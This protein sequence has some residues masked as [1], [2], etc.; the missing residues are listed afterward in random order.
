MKKILVVDDDQTVLQLVKAHLTPNGYQVVTANDGSEGLN[1]VQSEQ[2]DLIILDVQMPRMD[3]YTFVQE[4]KKQ[5]SSRQIPIIVIT[6]KEAMEEIFKLEG[7]R[8][9][10]TKPFEP[11]VLLEKVKIHLPA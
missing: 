2:P 7:V 11:T 1:K 5:K 9:Y 6:A 3:G 10:L 8:E 4:I